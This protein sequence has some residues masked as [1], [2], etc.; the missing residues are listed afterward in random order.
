MFHTFLLNKLEFVSILV[1]ALHCPTATDP[2]LEYL[3]NRGLTRLAIQ[4]QEKR[5]TSETD[6]LKRDKIATDLAA[7]YRDFFFSA[8]DEES[9]AAFVDRANWLSTNYPAINTPDFKLAIH[10]AKYIQVERNF[11]KWWRSSATDPGREAIFRQLFELERSIASQ[12]RGDEERQKDLIAANA[13]SP[14]DHFKQQQLIEQTEVRLLHNHYLFAWTSY[15]LA[16]SGEELSNSLLQQAQISFYRA[17]RIEQSEPIESIDAKWLDFSPPYSG[18]ALLGLASVYIALQRNTSADFC[19]NQA[20]SLHSPTFNR[21]I[22]EFNALAHARHW[23]SAVEFVEDYAENNVDGDQVVFWEA[24][25]H[26]GF[27]HN[28][29]LDT[30]KRLRFAGLLGL[31]REFAFDR[32]RHFAVTEEIDLPPNSYERRWIQLLAKYHISQPDGLD[33]ILAELNLL[34]ASLADRRDSLDVAKMQC[35]AALIEFKQGR[36]EN[37]FRMLQSIDLDSQKSEPTFA[38]RV[39]WLNSLV[40]LRRARQDPGKR[41]EALS[42]INQFI[43]DYPN[44]N[45]YQRAVFERFKLT[46]MILPAPQSLQQLRTI[47]ESHPFFSETQLQII[48]CLRR[49]WQES[50]GSDDAQEEFFQQLVREDVRIRASSEFTAAVKM[51]SRQVVL[52]IAVQRF[53]PN[54]DQSLIKTLLD[55]SQ[56][57][58]DGQVSSSRAFELDLAHAKF[59]IAQKSGNWQDAADLAQILAKNEI[60]KNY[61]IL[62]LAF[63]AKLVDDEERDFALQITPMETYRLLVQELGS[64]FEDLARS[65]NARVAATRLVE[66]YTENNLS[67]QTAKQLND[68]LLL[69]EPNRLDLLLTRARIA[70]NLGELQQAIK[71]WRKISAAEQA[72][73]DFW[74]EA[75]LGI[76]KCLLKTDPISAG[77]VL[78]QTEDL[79]GDI[80][81]KWQLNI[82]QL[83]SDILNLD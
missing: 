14:S 38:E 54:R 23:T 39:H 40:S 3:D 83:K 28:S 37:A 56:T 7:R 25:T 49:C 58:I 4:H 31:A 76:V 10:H 59:R 30:L 62:G 71:S 26:A 63:L 61:R 47:D 51:A 22:F 13:L 44:S 43:Q 65:K 32:L 68:T 11:R 82:N 6:E 66:I 74:F 41:N 48:Y 18:R 35:L 19:L 73:S 79:A 24:V 53:E 45:S 67:T 50:K 27:S 12:I 60:K 15:F 1:L 80:S 20:E 5:L 9:A 75:K 52:D 64:S 55:D 8:I 16:V 36:L 42:V 33:S 57:I 29:E 21:A 17:L 34:I 70:M 77:K 78:R 72:G 2:L 81:E 46:N 69:V